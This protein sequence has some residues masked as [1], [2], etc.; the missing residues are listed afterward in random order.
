MSTTRL[1][2]ISKCACQHSTRTRQRSTSY[3]NALAD[4]AKRHIGSSSPTTFS[5][6]EF[7]L[8]DVFLVIFI[9][10]RAVK[11]LEPRRSMSTR[12]FW[13]TCGHEPGVLANCGATLMY[14]RLSS[15]ACVHCGRHGDL[16]KECWVNTGQGH[17]QDRRSDAGQS[18]EDHTTNDK[19]RVWW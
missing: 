12:C 15:R 10:K 1:Q 7:Q 4:K 17:E 5:M 16:A 19:T 6:V 18:Q 3:S 11:F 14:I 9:L 8:E 2:I 13:R